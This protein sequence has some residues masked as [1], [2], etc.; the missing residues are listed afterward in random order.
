MWA[1][2][3]GEGAA[4]LCLGLVL[5]AALEILAILM[6]T[7]TEEE[8]MDYPDDV[9]PGVEPSVVPSKLPSAEPSAVPSL[10]PHQ[11][12]TYHP[13]SAR[14]RR[15]PTPVCTA[16]HQAGVLRRSS[17]A[18]AGHF[19]LSAT[20]TFQAAVTAIFHGQS[21][22]SNHGGT[23]THVAALLLDLSGLT[24][25]H[26]Q[27]LTFQRHLDVLRLL[28]NK[29]REL[30]KS[31]TYAAPV[32]ESEEKEGKEHEES[33]GVVAAKRSV[34]G[35]TPVQQYRQCSN[36]LYHAHLVPNMHVVERAATRMAS[37][38]PAWRIMSL[39]MSLGQLPDRWGRRS[40]W[41]ACTTG[42]SASLLEG[43]CWCNSVSQTVGHSNYKLVVAWLA[44]ALLAAPTMALPMVAM[45]AYPLGTLLTVNDLTGEFVGFKAEPETD[46]ATDVLSAAKKT[47]WSA[48]H[49]VPN[50]S[51]NSAMLVSPH[52]ALRGPAL[53][54]YH[55][56]RHSLPSAVGSWPEPPASHVAPR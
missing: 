37:R 42:H 56:A 38:Q 25:G 13:H 4:G 44:D 29:H 40:R 32:P 7:W 48:T 14:I 12:M 6:S 15:E 21:T 5:L 8:K 34:W 24:F 28:H 30:I 20:T 9:R 51:D 27:L 55:L 1:F 19:T 39:E 50:L 41:A 11:E 22:T 33:G 23:F 18:A 2:W 54:Q 16:A 3:F 35:V 47:N 10:V 52:L 45:T 43:I 17:L 53:V 36:R 26:F 31:V 46:D 49:G